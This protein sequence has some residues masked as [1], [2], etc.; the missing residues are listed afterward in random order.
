MGKDAEDMFPEAGMPEG[1]CDGNCMDCHE[2]HAQGMDED[3]RKRMAAIAKMLFGAHAEGM[4]EGLFAPQQQFEALIILGPEDKAIWD[5]FESRIKI[6]EDQ[7]NAWEAAARKLKTEKDLWWMNIR[8]KLPKADADRDTLKYTDDVIY[9]SVD[10]KESNAEL[11]SAQ[12]N[13]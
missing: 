7:K 3:K 13:G 11:G 1:G 6:L 4:L 12:H 10:T 8:E 5:D 2:P 9:G